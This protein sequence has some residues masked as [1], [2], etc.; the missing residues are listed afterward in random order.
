MP[1]PE[2]APHPRYTGPD[3]VDLD[4]IVVPAGLPE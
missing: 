3:P 1:D 4:S 2:T